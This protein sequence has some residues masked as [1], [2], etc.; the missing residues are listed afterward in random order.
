MAVELS[1]IV[2]RIL[3]TKCSEIG[4]KTVHHAKNSW[5]CLTANI[6]RNCKQVYSLRYEKVDVDVF[7]INSQVGV[8]IF[9]WNTHTRKRW[10]EL[11]CYLF[12]LGVDFRG[13][14]GFL[15]GRKVLGLWKWTEV[16]TFFTLVPWV[17]LTTFFW[18]LWALWTFLWGTRDLTVFSTAA[19]SAFFSVVFLGTGFLALG[20]L[21]LAAAGAL[22]VAALAAGALGASDFAEKV[23]QKVKYKV[24][25]TTGISLMQ[26]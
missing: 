13:Y 17:P 12:L 2:V 10:S 5:Y 16:R 8:V 11:K 20:T 26:A 15:A 9:T 24:D 6:H 18:I 22:A 14:F 7:R 3:N 23:R 21:G 25:S 1:V 4:S 19:P